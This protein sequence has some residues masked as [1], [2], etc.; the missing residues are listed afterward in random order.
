VSE[1]RWALLWNKA[2][3]KKAIPNPVDIAR[4]LLGFHML[5][6]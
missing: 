3:S 4:I 1:I 2:E 5:S 6:S